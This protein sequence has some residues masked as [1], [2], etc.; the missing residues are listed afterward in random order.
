MFDERCFSCV[1]VASVL[2]K[3]FWVCASESCRDDRRSGW[4]GR[5]LWLRSWVYVQAPK[6]HSS[7]AS[8]APARGLEVSYLLEL[9]S[10]PSCIECGCSLNKLKKIDNV[11]NAMSCKIDLGCP[12]YLPVQPSR[13]NTPALI[14]HKLHNGSTTPKQ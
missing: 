7:P 8:K 11:S 5:E 9:H 12:F 14:Y 13:L 2:T 1:V 10:P 4:I 3:F 6:H